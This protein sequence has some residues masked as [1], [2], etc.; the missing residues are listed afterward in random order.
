MLKYFFFFL[1]RKLKD[2]RQFSSA[3]QEK[4]SEMKWFDVR[5]WRLHIHKAQTLHV[6][7]C[8]WMKV[9]KQCT[10]SIIFHCYF[11]FAW[12]FSQTCC[13]YYAIHSFILLYYLAIHADPFL[14]LYFA[15]C[16]FVNVPFVTL[17]WQHACF[18]LNQTA[19]SSFASAISAG[20]KWKKKRR[21]EGGTKK[22][23]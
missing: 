12:F 20:M 11:N 16:S 15:L 6:V 9:L 17:E 8:E 19:S 5:F 22:N 13:E 1:L 23:M 4:K 3:K 21:R 7:I 14:L 2:K 10:S 18:F